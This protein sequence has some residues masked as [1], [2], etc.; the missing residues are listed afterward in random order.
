MQVYGFEMREFGY[1]R[2]FPPD[3]SW[4][5]MTSVLRADFE[6]WCLVVPQLKNQKLSFMP[7]ESAVGA[8]AWYVTL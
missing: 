2:Q 4:E 3:T 8:W 1:A 6:H 5:E 7:S